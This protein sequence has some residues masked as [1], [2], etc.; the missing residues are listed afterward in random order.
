MSGGIVIDFAY[1][2][3]DQ[4]YHNREAL[5]MYLSDYGVNLVIFI[6]QCAYQGTSDSKSFQISIQSYQICHQ[7]QAPKISECLHLL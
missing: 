7:N 1:T 3:I 6:K 4:K 2:C 5:C